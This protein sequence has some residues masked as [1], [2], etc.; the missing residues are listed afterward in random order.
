MGVIVDCRPWIKTMDAKC[1][2]ISQETVKNSVNEEL[3]RNFRYEVCVK[4]IET[5][6]QKCS[7]VK[8]K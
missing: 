3:Q 4:C 5:H 6:T 2:L 1:C 7:N 8:A